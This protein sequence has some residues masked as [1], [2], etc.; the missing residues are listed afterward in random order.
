M[1]DLTS[2]KGFTAIKACSTCLNSS[3]E[4]TAGSPAGILPAPFG[5]VHFTAIV[6]VDGAGVSGG[7]ANAAWNTDKLIQSGPLP[8]VAG[9][10]HTFSSPPHSAFA[11]T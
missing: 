11:D 6:V 7:L 2:G 1:H 5:A 9:P 8:T 10:L 4:V 3:A